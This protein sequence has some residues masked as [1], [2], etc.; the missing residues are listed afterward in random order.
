MILQILPRGR[1]TCPLVRILEA[2]CGN[3]LSKEG[4]SAHMCTLVFIDFLKEVRKS[5]PWRR[6]GSTSVLETIALSVCL[7]LERGEREG[8][9]L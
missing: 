5:E 3:D 1:P 9:R 8:F 6:Y 2:M 4:T 7:L